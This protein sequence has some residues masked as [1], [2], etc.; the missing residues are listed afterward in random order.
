MSVLLESLLTNSYTL[1]NTE[2]ASGDL[3]PNLLVHPLFL[4]CVFM[5][6]TAD[7]L[8]QESCG[9]SWDFREEVAMGKGKGTYSFLFPTPAL[10]SY[11][12]GNELLTLSPSFHYTGNGILRE[13]P[14]VLS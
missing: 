9:S 11:L 12:L 10:A 13:A 3:Q 2:Q 4:M 14:F 8:E 5:F 6:C 1:A 7:T